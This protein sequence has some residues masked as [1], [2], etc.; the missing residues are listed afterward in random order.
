METLL[1]AIVTWLAVNFN[2]PA[3]YEHPRIELASAETM[4]AV[5]YRRPGAT[6]AQPAARTVRPGQLPEVEAL[7]DDATRTLYLP[8]EWTGRTPRE[9]SVLV[10]E[11]VHHLQNAAGLRY[12][13]AQAREKPAYVAQSRW[14]ELFGRTLGEEFGIDPMTVLVRTACM[15]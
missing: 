5:R 7:Y 13:C 6:H 9:L 15:H 4:H 3:V 2:L 12:E 14:L 10:H 11:M 1:T 8:E